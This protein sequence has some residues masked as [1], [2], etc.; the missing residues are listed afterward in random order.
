VERHIASCSE[1]DGGG[2]YK[3]VVPELKKV[4]EAMTWLEHQ[5]VNEQPSLLYSY[6]TSTE[7]YVHTKM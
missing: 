2:S 3:V 7:N 1:D 6:L 5:T 4:F